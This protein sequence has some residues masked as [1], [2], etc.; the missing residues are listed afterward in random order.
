MWRAK[1]ARLPQRVEPPPYLNTF[2][3]QYYNAMR[4]ARTPRL[5]EIPGIQTQ[6][7][8]I[9]SSRRLAQFGELVPQGSPGQ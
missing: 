7:T 5:E 6:R 8:R 4:L 9:F 3:Q 2:T 1:S